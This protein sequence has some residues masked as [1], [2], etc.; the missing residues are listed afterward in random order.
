MRDVRSIFVTASLL[1]ASAAVGAHD[2]S[3]SPVTWNRE[4]SRIVYDRCASCHR[5]GG[6]AFSLMTYRDAQPR[7]VAIRDTVL[8]RRMPPWGGVKGF[9]DFRNDQGLT[10]E[11]IELV[12]AWVE[13]DTPKGNNP[14]VLP[15]V[16][17]P[18]TPAPFRPPADSIRVSNELTLRQRIMLD[19]VLPQGVPD[20]SSMQITAR[21]PDGAVTPLVWLYEYRDA[22][23]HPFLFR[24]PVELPAG[25]VIR[26]VM[27]PASI[28]LLPSDSGWYATIRR[29]IAP[30]IR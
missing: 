30:V 9:G 14:N 1:V 22:Y 20:G 6:S 11:Q 28:L 13:G 21:Q 3:R 29:F 17:K 8:A 27:G 26:G 2:F 16:P 19:G 23:Q 25:T 5:E 7:A 18:V 10:Q 4:I 15:E 24:Q 12:A